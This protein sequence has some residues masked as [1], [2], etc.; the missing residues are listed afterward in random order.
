MHTH[1]LQQ[2]Y[3][4]NNTKQQHVIYD[5]VNTKDRNSDEHLND[6]TKDEIVKG[7]NE[8]ANAQQE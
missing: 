4:P 5:Y 2:Y 1:E 3:M 7:L 8:N 6:N